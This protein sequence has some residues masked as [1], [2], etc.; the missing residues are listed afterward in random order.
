MDMSY[1]TIPVFSKQRILYREKKLEYMVSIPDRP[2]NHPVYVVDTDIRASIFYNDFCL[3]K[4]SKTEPEIPEKKGEQLQEEL[5]SDQEYD[6][7]YGLW[8]IDLMELSVKKELGK[9]CELFLQMVLQ[10][11]FLS[12]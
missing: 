4:G 9:M 5:I 7:D 8:N 1:A 10:I 6:D 12:N 11:F 3:E 2:N